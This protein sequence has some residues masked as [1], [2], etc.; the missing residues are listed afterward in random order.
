M[1]NKA[2]TW[3]PV[4]FLNVVGEAVEDVMVDSTMSPTERPE[5]KNEVNEGSNFTKVMPKYL[6]YFY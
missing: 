2:N 3:I 6:A 1:R 5:F 4:R